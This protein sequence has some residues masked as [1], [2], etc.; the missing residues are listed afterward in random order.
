MTADPESVA[1]RLALADDLA[2]TASSLGLDSYTCPP[3]LCLR[4]RTHSLVVMPSLR[5]LVSPDLETKAPME[6][7]AELIEVR[8]MRSPSPLILHV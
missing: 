4:A 2:A 3:E 5:P 7:M 6:A 8:A 1:G